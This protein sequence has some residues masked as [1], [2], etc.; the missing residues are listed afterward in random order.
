MLSK[1]QIALKKGFVEAE[2]K[3]RN[4]KVK[5][6]GSPSLDATKNKPLAKDGETRTI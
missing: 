4:K 2:N 1:E 3:R 6:A 5:E